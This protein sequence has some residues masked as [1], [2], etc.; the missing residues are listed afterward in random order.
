MAA[1]AVLGVFGGGH[2]TAARVPKHVVVFAVL[3]AELAH[4]TDVGKSLEHLGQ[5]PIRA[6]ADFGDLRGRGTL[7][8]GLVALVRLEVPPRALS[9]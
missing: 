1:A 4:G 9:R 7:E 5:R 8:D 3:F 6:L 2:A